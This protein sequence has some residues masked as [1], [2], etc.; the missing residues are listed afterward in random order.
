[1]FD[2]IR[3]DRYSVQHLNVSRFAAIQVAQAGV[4]VSKK[5]VQTVQNP[6][7]L[8]IGK[9]GLTVKAANKENTVKAGF[10]S[11]IVRFIEHDGSV[12]EFILRF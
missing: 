3:F 10:S 2:V 7:M 1:M 5:T 11:T 4:K 8:F 9:N 6:R 12:Q